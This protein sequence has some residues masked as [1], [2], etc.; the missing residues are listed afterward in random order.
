VGVKA[1]GTPKRTTFFPANSSFVE[2]EAGPFSVMC[3][4]VASGNVSPAWIAIVFL[5]EEPKPSF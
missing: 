2:R 5:L 4:T 3:I 1:P